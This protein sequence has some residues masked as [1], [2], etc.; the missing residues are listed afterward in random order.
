PDLGPLNPALSGVAAEL[1]IQAREHDR[2]YDQASTFGLEFGYGFSDRSEMFGQVRQ[3]RAGEGRVVVG[4]AYVPA[5]QAGLPVYG[6]FGA[7]EALSAELGYRHFFG[8]AGSARPFIGGRLGATRVD[9]IRATFEIPDGG[10]TI[11]NAA[12]YE[13]GWV[14]T[15]GLDIGVI[16]PVSDTF[17]FT[18]ASGVHYASDLKDNDSAIGGLGLARINDTGSRV[19]VPVTLSARWDF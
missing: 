1:R 14:A 18:L 10:I 17:S 3:T 11:A 6:T 9:D 19:S 4:E 16:V 7:Y 5:L 15:G 13:A 2:I 12:F 8:T